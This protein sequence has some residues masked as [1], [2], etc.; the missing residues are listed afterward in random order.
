VDR[1]HAPRWPFGVLGFLAE[2]LGGG[3]FKD[4]GLQP[5]H[6]LAA[7]TTHR[8][9]DSAQFGRVVHGA[10]LGRQSAWA[11]AR[12]PSA[13]FALASVLHFLA[14]RRFCR[15]LFPARVS[16][17]S[18]AEWSKA[19]AQGASPQGRGLEPHSCHSLCNSLD[20]LNSLS[21]F[22]KSSSLNTPIS[23][24]SRSSLIRQKQSDQPKQSA[25]SNAQGRSACPKMGF[26]LL[27]LF[28]RFEYP[29]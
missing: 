25:L 14:Q 2:R 11:W 10:G 20:R 18:L 16:H 12:T 28:R 24:N 4:H 13:A 22:N 29:D 26:R 3:T 17:Y 6:R 9:R 1:K 23:L 8:G 15:C 7:R 19:L 5:P 27:V 21:S